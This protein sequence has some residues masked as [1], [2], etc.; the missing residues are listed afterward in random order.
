MELAPPHGH[1]TVDPTSVAPVAA[2]P[3]SS[4]GSSASMSAAAAPFEFTQ[5]A[6]R[7][8]NCGKL[9]RIELSP[10]G[11]SCALDRRSAI[12]VNFQTGIP[13]VDDAKMQLPAQDCVKSLSNVTTITETDTDSPPC[14][15]VSLTSSSPNSTTNSMS[16][17]SA[18]FGGVSVS[19]ATPFDWSTIHTGGEVQLGVKRERAEPPNLA[20]YSIPLDS[21]STSAA[22][23]VKLASSVVGSI[24]S[25]DQAQ[26]TTT[27][28]V[29]ATNPL[30]PSADS[31][32]LTSPLTKAFRQSPHGSPVGLSALPFLGPSSTPS[33]SLP[34][35]PATTT[36]TAAAAAAAPASA[37]HL[38]FQRVDQQPAAQGVPSILTPQP[39]YV[40][41]FA[42]PATNTKTEQP[43]VSTPVRSVFQQPANQQAQVSVFSSILPTMATVT[44]NA[45]STTPAA[46]PFS[47]LASTAFT[48]GTN[49]SPLTNLEA[50]LAYNSLYGTATGL[51]SSQTN[52]IEYLRYTFRA[53]PIALT[54]HFAMTTPSATTASSSES[55]VPIILA[56][57]P[58]IPSTAAGLIGAPGL[59]Q[60]LPSILAHYGV[61]EALKAEHQMQEALLAA[62]NK[63]SGET[64][65]TDKAS[66]SQGKITMAVAQLIPNAGEPIPALVAP[67]VVRLIHWLRRDPIP[68]LNSSLY[69]VLVAPQ[70]SLDLPESKNVNRSSELLSPTIQQ[71]V[72]YQLQ[73][74]FQVQYQIQMQYQAQIQQQYQYQQQQ[75][76]V[77]LQ[78]QQQQLQQPQ[79]QPQPSQQQAIQSHSSVP[80][81]AVQPLQHASE[82]QPS[83]S[84][85]AAAPTTPF[86]ASSQLQVSGSPSQFSY[87]P[88]D[89]A[90]PKVEQPSTSIGMSTMPLSQQPISAA[91]TN[92]TT[93]GCMTDVTMVIQPQPVP[94]PPSNASRTQHSMHTSHSS[95]KHSSHHANL[96]FLA[97]VPPYNPNAG[98]PQ[99]TSAS[100][101]KGNGRQSRAGVQQLCTSLLQ[102]LCADP[103][104]S[105]LVKPE[106]W[107][108]LRR[109]RG[110]RPD[111]CIEQLVRKVKS[112]RTSHALA[113]DLRLVLENVLVY[114]PYGH[115]ARKLAES[116]WN[117]LV[118][119]FKALAPP[120]RV[121]VEGYESRTPVQVKFL[122]SPGL[123][124]L[125]Y[126][127][128][129]LPPAV[130]RRLARRAG[131]PRPNWP[132]RWLASCCTADLDHPLLLPDQETGEL[133]PATPR[134]TTL[135]NEVVGEL[136]YGSS[137]PENTAVDSTS[138]RRWF[139]TESQTKL[140]AEIARPFESLILP[141]KEKIEELHKLV[142]VLP[143]SLSTPSQR[144]PYSTPSRSLT[145]GATCPNRG[146][147]TPTSGSCQQTNNLFPLPP[148]LTPTEPSMDQSTNGVGT[149]AAKGTTKMGSR[150]VAAAATSNKQDSQSD[151]AES[152]KERKRHR[153]KKI[154]FVRKLVMNRVIHVLR[155]RGKL[156]YA[157]TPRP[158][159]VRSRSEGRL[160][161]DKPKFYYY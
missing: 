104:C 119:T 29:L 57:S 113:W 74:Y 71:Q 118:A 122:C 145:G 131:K 9:E 65:S 11:V 121:N 46:A 6:A 76:Q 100:A 42:T 70:V 39:Q 62:N 110:W 143:R 8:G 94:A 82:Q 157:L 126:S 147:K 50:F 159:G 78:Q 69:P 84:H 161:G 26:Q 154:L 41:T 7:V 134:L 125:R 89:T 158:P 51:T 96:P 81:Q 117:R 36:T 103:G 155:S 98:I 109:T 80:P 136:A 38:Q 55:I 25:Q 92:T 10:G 5:Q 31:D 66:S 56:W 127:A 108:T 132:K 61:I 53:V 95:S 150:S 116:V 137:R 129:S 21:T 107:S 44:H 115:P 75:P 12:E 139:L 99:W 156:P 14:S 114:H 34:T 77:Y 60:S 49:P 24:P 43:P 123:Q 149:P 133:I 33:T 68:E 90:A 86:P 73:L 146:F 28:S 97:R 141:V 151:Q 1:R 87:G 160:D 79:P 4:A 148:L 72:R 120:Y 152:A 13:N 3:V 135:V 91:S 83:V 93:P 142:E 20:D 85:S 32:A 40:G 17:P 47:S 52:M 101:L 22:K 128:T 106:T 138:T 140:L 54:V 37:N 144:L 112:Y 153:L 130:R 23:L 16:V 102:A 64:G 30:V 15:S 88:S 124:R 67:N 45:A 27:R 35:V 19:A 63:Q 59:L 58:H 18:T 105:W 2:L 48:T 111:L